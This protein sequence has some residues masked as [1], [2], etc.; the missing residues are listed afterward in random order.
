MV[1]NGDAATAKTEIFYVEFCKKFVSKEEIQKRQS[2][3]QRTIPPMP[4]QVFMKDVVFQG[5]HNITHTNTYM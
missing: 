2:L 4:P 1:R 3:T 5:Q